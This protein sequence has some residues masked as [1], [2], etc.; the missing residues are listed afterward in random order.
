MYYGFLRF[1]GPLQIELQRDRLL[2]RSNSTSRLFVLL[3]RAAQVDRQLLR[4]TREARSFNVVTVAFSTE[5]V[6]DEPD[7]QPAS[8]TADESPPM[9]NSNGRTPDTC[10][11]QE[12]HTAATV[13]YLRWT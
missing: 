3:I 9:S 6:E 8:H 12:R 2:P 11:A 10:D 5:R 1:G 7:P 13:L 4:A